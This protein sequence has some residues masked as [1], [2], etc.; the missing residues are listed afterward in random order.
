M[1]TLCPI[2]LT[3]VYAMDRQLKMNGRSYHLPCAKCFVCQSQLSNTN[4]IVGK[5]GELLCTVHAKGGVG[6]EGSEEISPPH[7]VVNNTKV[8]EGEKRGVDGTKD[9]EKGEGYETMVVE[10]EG[11]TRREAR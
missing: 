1:T 7:A 2:C 11:E 4:V 3:S 5:G 8:D 6:R 10:E 9:G